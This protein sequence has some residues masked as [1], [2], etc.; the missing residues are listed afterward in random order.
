MGNFY[1]EWLAVGG[2]IQDAFKRAPHV[3][4]DRDIPWVS[5][6]QD[7]K[8]K[9]MMSEELGYVTP[10]SNVLKAEIPVGWHTVRHRHG[11]ESMHILQGQG[12]SIID[13]QRFDWHTGSTLQIPYRA[14]HQHFN[15]GIVPAVYISGMCFSLEK[16]LKIAS[17][18]QL[19]TCGEN[20]PA[21]LAEM[22]VQES[23]Y[24]YNGP[25]AIIHLE[26]APDVTGIS[27]LE[28]SRNQHHYIKYLVSPENGFKAQS[29]AVTN[30]WE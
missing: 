13:G 11:E 9:L 22:P 19:E 2:E 25:R 10:G 14:D 15:T 26:D 27:P 17:L 18:E 29:V 6:P 5:T 1:D 7:A 16:Y 4:R 28:A 24:Y 20:D 12:F 8:V 23:Q 3:A 30:V 21:E